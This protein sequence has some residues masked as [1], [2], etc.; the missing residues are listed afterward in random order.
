[1]PP[2]APNPSVS[3]MQR[4]AFLEGNW[5]GQGWH[6]VARGGE[7]RHLSQTEHVKRVLDGDLLTI[8]GSGRAAEDPGRVVHRAFAIVS[9]EAA[10]ARYRW[11][12][13]SR[14]DR[15]E[16]ELRVTDTTFEWSAQLAPSTLMRYRATVNGDHWTETGQLSTD[17]GTT[18]ATTLQLQLRRTA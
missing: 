5:H 11:E 10:T 2:N 12:A 16:T 14:G 18:W 6:Q 7:R 1:M 15:L 13:F 17:Q 8:E 4:L 3:A 9:Y